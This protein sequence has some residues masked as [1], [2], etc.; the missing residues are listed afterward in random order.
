[1]FP[2]EVVRCLS[3]KAAVELLCDWCGWCVMGLADEVC[4][5]DLDLSIF[6]LELSKIINEN[7][8]KI[9]CL[10]AIQQNFFGQ[11]VTI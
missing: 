11:Y 10:Y 7:T 6:D 9:V 5:N 1:M 4:L 8:K 3:K 2:S